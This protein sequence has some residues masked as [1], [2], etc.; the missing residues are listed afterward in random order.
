MAPAAC[1]LII[2]FAV[3]I[4][5]S[6]TPNSMD[7]TGALVLSV[8]GLNLGLSAAVLAG[9][10]GLHVQVGKYEPCEAMLTFL[11]EL[12]PNAGSGHRGPG[13]MPSALHR[14]GRGRSAESAPV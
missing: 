3:P 5:Q 2:C 7:V 8:T 1:M 4:I 9:P 6:L 14:C 13:F 12:L 10:I 11:S